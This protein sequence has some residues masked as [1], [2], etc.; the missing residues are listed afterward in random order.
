MSGLKKVVL[1]SRGSELACAQ[2]QLVERALRTEYPQ[3]EIETK[4]IR[5]SGDVRCAIVENAKAKGSQAGSMSHG[6]KGLF[7]REIERALES[8]AIDVAVHSAKDLPSEAT[9]GLEVRGALPRGSMDDVLITK[10]S[11]GWKALPARATV[12]TGS[13]RR[14]YQLRSHRGDLVI[15]G[16]RGNVPTRLRKLAEQ[17]W[18]AIVLARAGLERLGF[19]LSRGEI[20]FESARFYI[21]A[22]PVD[23]FVPAGGQGIIALQ[24]RRDGGGTRGLVD[25]ISHGET[26][27]CLRAEREFLRLLQGDCDSPVGVFARITGSEM[28]MRAQLFEPPSLVARTALVERPLAGI[29]PEQLAADLMDRMHGG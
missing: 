7:T 27:L 11:G 2:T 26:L 16:L 25:A 10:C 13:V 15:A 3:L 22:L 5:T 1:G 9:P 6:R 17:D 14:D 19:D 20:L 24:V 4:I 23:N 28:E 21:E 8:G 29:N 12:G 18:D